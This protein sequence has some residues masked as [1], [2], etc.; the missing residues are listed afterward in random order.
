MGNNTTVEVAFA[1]SAR[2]W[3]VSAD[4]EVFE[5]AVP[6]GDTRGQVCPNTGGTDF[7]ALTSRPGYLSVRTSTAASKAATGSVTGMNSVRISKPRTG[8]HASSGTG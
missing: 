8:Y 5:R 2:T 1:T 3:V 7:G 4:L 6:Q